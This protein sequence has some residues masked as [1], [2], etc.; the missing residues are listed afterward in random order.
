MVK[1]DCFKRKKV[2]GSDPEAEFKDAEE[3]QKLNQEP[4]QEL[5]QEPPQQQ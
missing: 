1:S 3:M 4:P 2:P 5:P